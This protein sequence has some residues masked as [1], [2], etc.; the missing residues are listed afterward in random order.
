MDQTDNHTNCNLTVVTH[1][2]VTIKH[3]RKSH[4][5]S[6]T[7][8]SSLCTVFLKQKRTVI[9]A[10]LN[11]AQTRAAATSAYRVPKS[12]S[13]DG[14]MTSSEDPILAPVSEGRE[15]SAEERVL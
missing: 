10:A 4:V 5:D 11:E 7:Q 12:E 15:E 1:R 8:P 3:Y 13:A 14:I 2:H 9:L 6:Q